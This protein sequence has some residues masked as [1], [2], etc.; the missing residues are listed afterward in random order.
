MNGTGM[1]QICGVLLTLLVMQN[2]NCGETGAVPQE[3]VKA[4]QGAVR[5]NATIQPKPDS[6]EI[7]YE[8]IN[9]TDQAV[10]VFDRMWDRAKKAID[11][12]WADVEIRGTKALIS[13]SLSKKPEG[14]FFD[15]PPVPYGREVAP[16]KS[17]S[18][19]FSVKLPLEE[20]FGFY[21]FIRQTGE[22]KEIPVTE[23]AFALGWTL[24]PQ[25]L[26]PGVKPVDVGE[27]KG[28]L[29]LPYEMLEPIEKLVISQPLRVTVS[30]R[31]K[32]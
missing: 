29:L 23:V 7:S 5:L 2:S 18:G 24:K 4:M 21:N 14:L 25:S 11:P 26:P 22:W 28:L 30:A 3:E 31:A 6:L 16:G 9:S 27:D 17:L 32:R 19:K 13:R 10:L 1:L 15:N 8:F 20:R 12:E